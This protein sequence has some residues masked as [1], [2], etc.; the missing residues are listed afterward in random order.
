MTDIMEYINPE[1]LILIPVIYVLG[2]VLKS[3][4]TVK[5]KYIPLILGV[6]GIVLAMLY[7]LTVS[8]FCIEVFYT[9]IVQG[10]LVSAVA[11]YGNQLYVQHK[12]DE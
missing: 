3:M 8:G 4:E 11:V 9:A 2:M 6:T 1:L 7:S 5:D 10:I 12:K